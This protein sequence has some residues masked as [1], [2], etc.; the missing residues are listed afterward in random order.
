MDL[1]GKQLPSV[2]AA[3]NGKV[4]GVE[5]GAW[6]PIMPTSTSP[7]EDLPLNVS[8]GIATLDVTN[9][10]GI[11]QVLT[12][13]GQGSNFQFVGLNVQSS[14]DNILIFTLCGIDTSTTNFHIDLS[15][16]S[17]GRA[18]YVRLRPVST[19]VMSG[20]L[21]AYTLPDTIIYK[22]SRKL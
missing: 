12:Q 6:R 11:Q 16:V 1:I 19:N 3:D 18:Y 4:L 9:Q 20:E 22:H 8:E 15:C 13:Y 7:I 21:K 14:P 5:N 17:D 2:S 10:G